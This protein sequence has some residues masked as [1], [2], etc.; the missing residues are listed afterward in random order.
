MDTDV[1]HAV[2]AE[3]DALEARILAL[4]EAAGVAPESA[5]EEEEDA[6][7]TLPYGEES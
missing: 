5:D 6:A 7:A 1:N 4:E 2:Q 3:L